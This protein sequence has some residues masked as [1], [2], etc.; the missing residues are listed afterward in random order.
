MVY[1]FGF[2]E[3][4]RIMTVITGGLFKSIKSKA[5][6]RLSSYESVSSSHMTKRLVQSRP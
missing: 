6:P 2:R 3:G 5:A 1:K 4:Y